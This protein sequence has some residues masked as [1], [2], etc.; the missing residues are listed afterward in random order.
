[1]TLRWA[2]APPREYKAVRDRKRESTP[3]KRSTRPRTPN[4]RGHQPHRGDEAR[5]PTRGRA[6]TEEGGGSPPTGAPKIKETTARNTPTQN[7]TSQTQEGTNTTE[8]DEA[9]HPTMGRAR[10]DE[11]GGSPPTRA[12]K[13]QEAT[14][15]NTPT[16]NR[17]S[18][19][20][21]GTN[22]TEGTRHDAP[23]WGE[24]DK[25]RGEDRHRRRRRRYKE[26]TT[27]T[28]PTQNRTS[29]AH[30]GTN[31]T[32]GTRHDAPRWGERNKTNKRENEE[33]P[34]QPKPRKNNR[35]KKK[36]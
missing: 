16:Q 2:S 30:E 8:G 4:P 7:R 21:E 15:R 33:Q 27:R 28:T 32:E 24:R 9:R 20:H 22:P 19:P 14:A 17:T 26:A 23:R 5:R 31:P 3:T 35:T 11:G 13:I 29:Q 6:R 34:D 25:T 18:Q 10:Q 1:M 36:K 12:P